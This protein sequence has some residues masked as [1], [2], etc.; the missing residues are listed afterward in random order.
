MAKKRIHYRR[1]LKAP[2]TH[3]AKHLPSVLVLS[4]LI[5][6]VLVS[7]CAAPFIIAGTVAGAGTTVVK[8]RR[9]VENIIEDEV[10]ELRSTDAIYSDKIIGKHVRINTTSFNGIVLLTG[11]APSA[12]MRA[13]AGHVAYS[14][15]NV[16]EVYNEVQIK[17]P[18]SLEQRAKD[19]WLGTKVKSKLIANR[20]LFTRAKVIA[21]DNTIYLMGLV[22]PDEADQIKVMVNELEG[23]NS[24]I[25]L[26]EPLADDLSDVLRDSQL[27]IRKTVVGEE[28][29]KPIEQQ[30]EDDMSVL[31]YTEPANIQLTDG[32]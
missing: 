28:P 32:K 14:M 27:T 12:E 2:M 24:I 30:D 25:A 1:F 22:T 23:V 21:S 15:R 13:H 29:K 16:R 7:G 11:E 3:N 26:F 10:I 8:D 4:T 17:T 31:P 20:G 6:S 18:I 9:N 5:L 19:T